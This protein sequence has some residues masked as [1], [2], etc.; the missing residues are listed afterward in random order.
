MTTQEALDIYNKYRFT[1]HSI[2]DLK[3]VKPATKAVTALQEISNSIEKEGGKLQ[4]RQVI[5]SIIYF[6]VN[7]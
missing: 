4:S 5:A 7:S 6:S 3:W 2:E 1:N